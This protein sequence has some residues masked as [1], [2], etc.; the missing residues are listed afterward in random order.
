M[1]AQRLYEKGP[2]DERKY[3]S[4]TEL[5]AARADAKK[6]MVELCSEQ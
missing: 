2:N 5:D 4:D 6:V 3:L 1:S